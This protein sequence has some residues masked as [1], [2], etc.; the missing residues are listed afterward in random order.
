[1]GLAEP[2]RGAC[3]PHPQHHAA[4]ARPPAPADA[5]AAMLPH[6]VGVVGASNAAAPAQ[7]AAPVVSASVTDGA[8]AFTLGGSSVTPRVLTAAKA[9]DGQLPGHT[10]FRCAAPAHAWTRPPTSHHQRI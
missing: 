9:A 5:L 6:G 1:V 8:V 3:C 10:I 7:A 2:L 4:T